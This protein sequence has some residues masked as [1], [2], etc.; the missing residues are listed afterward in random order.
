MRRAADVR[1]HPDPVRAAL[2][3]HQP[4]A[5]RPLPADLQQADVRVRGRR[6]RCWARSAR[7]TRRASGSSSGGSARPSTS[8][9]SWCCCRCSASSS[10]RCRCP[11]AS[12]GRCCAAAAA[13]CRRVRPPPRWRSPDALVRPGRP[14]RHRGA[15]VRPADRGGCRALT[16]ASAASLGTFD[17]ASAQRGFAGLQRG[18]LELPLA[19]A[20]VLPQPRG[21]RAVG[22][23]G[24]GDRGRQAGADHRRRRPPAERPA[25]PSD[26]F[27]SPFPNDKAARAAN[28]G[29]LPPDQSVIEKAREGGAS[30]I[31]HLVGTATSMRRPTSRSAT[32]CTTTNGSPATRSPCRR[33]CPRA[34]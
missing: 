21:D 11:R 14:D 13:R 19:E 20:C 1:L 27:R 6:A 15:G 3:R 10:G 18:L 16:G 17:R 5:Q 34:W 31:D 24:E 12:A 22:G 7:T 4:G 26:H 2:A 23:A 25:L 33:R 29:A 9:T 8:C 28:N 32:V 30:Y